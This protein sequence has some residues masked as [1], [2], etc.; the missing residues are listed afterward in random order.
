MD[1]EIDP[2][3][4]TDLDGVVDWYVGVHDDMDFPEGPVADYTPQEKMKVLRDM[5]V[6]SDCGDFALAI[7]ERFGWPIVNVVSSRNGAVHSA[8]LHPDGRLVDFDGFVT[9][10][11]LKKRYR[12]RDLKVIPA[13]QTGH[14]V[15]TSVDEELGVSNA[16]IVMPH[17]HYAPFN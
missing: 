3:L 7:H 1:D 16:K 8:C 15:G 4:P 5:F 9:L 11:A 10:D 13:E 6:S 12:M 17:L 2:E 14:V